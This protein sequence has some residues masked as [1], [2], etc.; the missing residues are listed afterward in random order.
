MG[1]ILTFAMI[2]FIAIGILALYSIVKLVMGR[3][4]KVNMLVN[5]FEET[6][7]NL[8][9]K[10][11]IATV[12]EK[13]TE[14]LQDEYSRYMIEMTKLTYPEDQGFVM[15]MAQKANVIKG[16]LED[17]NELIPG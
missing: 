10:S 1:L 7:A 8:D 11:F 16:I 3:E 2:A 15:E 13:T 5:A 6:A 14:E 12:V 4:E 9:D 17:R